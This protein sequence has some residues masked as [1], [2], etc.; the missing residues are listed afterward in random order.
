MLVCPRCLG[1]VV[2]FV[3][4][5]LASLTATHMPG[6]AAEIV[7]TLRRTSAPEVGKVWQ[8]TDGPLLTDAKLNHYRLWFSMA[9]Y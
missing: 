3:C 2:R 1:H 5:A 9:V 4:S 8:G 6:R 7:H